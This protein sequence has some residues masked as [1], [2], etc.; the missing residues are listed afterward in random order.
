MK[1]L[2][3]ACC[4][5]CSM[6]PLRILLAEGHDISIFYANSNIAPEPEYRHRLSELLKFAAHEGVRVI[7]GN[8]DPAQWER[9]VAPIGRAMAQKAQERTE[10]PTSVAELLDDAN[11]RNRCRACYKLR[12]CEAARYA[13]EHDFD[14]VSTTLSVSPYQFIDIIREELTRACKQNS[15]APDFRDFRPYYDE[16]TRRSREAGM[17]RQDYCGCSFSI[18]EGEATRAFIKEQRE[19]QRAL[20]LIAHEAERKAEAEK[21]RARKAE[22]AS[23]NAKQARKRDLLRQFKEQQRAQEHEQQLREQA[24]GLEQA[25]KQASEQARELEQTLEQ[26]RELLEKVSEQVA[27]SMVISAHEQV[28]HQAP[29]ADASARDT[30]RLVHE[31]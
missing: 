21:R 15:I 30:E 8:Y 20:Y 12:L 11:R 10:K 31:N 24:R 17:Y 26:K 9:Y 16:A 14:A 29:L 13:H 18:A 4:G 2:L 19:E 22:Q 28:L 25:S 7:E 3:H 6:E 27:G 1:L 5:P 23:Y